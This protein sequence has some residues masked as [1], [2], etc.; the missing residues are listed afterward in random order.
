MTPLY[1]YGCGGMGFTVIEIKRAGALG[2]YDVK[3]WLDDS[4]ER[5]GTTLEGIEVVGG[6]GQLSR[7]GSGAAMIVCIG[8]NEVRCRIAR[9]AEALGVEFPTAIHPS[10]T[11][12][13]GVEL[14]AGCIVNAGA[15]IARHTRIGP[16][17]IVNLTATVGHDVRAGTGT[18]IS[19]GVN[20]A[21][22]VTIG[23][24]VFIGPGA[25]V[26]Q[27]RAVGEWA[28]VGAGAVVIRDVEPHTTVF[29][30]PARVVERRTPEVAS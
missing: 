2:S 5:H 1:L 10:A 8:D 27:G 29:G 24:G 3:G 20:I 28:R 25:V 9:E 30:N 4:E 26:I 16:H 7:L 19:P 21:G 17:S 12:F 22:G 11:L 15:V 18:Q 23:D 13:E 6:R 14:G